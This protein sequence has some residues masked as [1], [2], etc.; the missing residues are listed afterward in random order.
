MFCLDKEDRPVTS[1]EDRAAVRN[2][3]HVIAH[4][5]TDQAFPWE[6]YIHKAFACDRR[7]GLDDDFYG[8]SLGPFKK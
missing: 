5:R 6:P 2:V 3:G 8:L 1:F 7:T 4:V